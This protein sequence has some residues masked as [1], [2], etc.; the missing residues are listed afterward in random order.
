M[1][2]E[3][4][5]Y[6]HDIKELQKTDL[7]IIVGTSLNVYPVAEIPETVDSSCPRLY[8]NKN[9]KDNK[10]CE[11]YNQR[12]G[13]DVEYI[14]D[15]DDCCLEIAKL[16]HWDKKLIQLKRDY[17]FSHTNTINQ[18]MNTTQETENKKQTD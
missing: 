1:P 9:K 10:N 2:K 11:I 18:S 12:E 7:L 13:G 5:W 3:Y 17:D 4:H 15:C 6:V 8:I 16:L 14:G